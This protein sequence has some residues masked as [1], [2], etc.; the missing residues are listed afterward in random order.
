[1]ADEIEQ[2]KT[3]VKKLKLKQ[4]CELL[5]GH[6]D[7]WTNE[8]PKAN[9]KAVEMH[10]GPLGLRKPKTAQGLADSSSQGLPATC[11][12]APCLTACSWDPSFLEKMGQAVAREALEQ[13]TDIVLAPGVNI[14]RNP[15]CGRNFEYFSEDPLLAGKMG[16]GYIRGVQA[17][18][19]GASLK[20]FA[21]NNQEYRRFIYSAEVDE[22]AL[23]ELYLKPFEIAVKEAKPWTV[24][25][26]YNRINGVYSSEND[27]LL[28]DVLRKEWGY[29]GCVISDWGAVYDPI[30]CHNHGLDLEMPCYENRAKQLKKAVKKGVLKMEAVDA[31][32]ARVATLSFLAA[33]RPETQGA[34]NYGM[35][36]QIALDVAEKSIVL[37]K[38][39]GDILPFKSFDDVCLVGGLAKDFLYQG[40]GSS[41]VT[42]NKVVSLY[43]S[44]N[45]GREIG[46]EIAFEQGYP[47]RPGEDEK[48]LLINAVDLASTHKT[49]LLCLG[50][51]SFYL[52]EGYD[53]SDMRLPEE[54]YR[55]FDALYAVNPNIVVVL[56]LGSPVELLFADRANAIMIAYL[57][58]EA[59]G[60][61]IR[62]LLLGVVNPSG[63]LAETWPLHY[64]DVPSKDYYPGTGTTSLYKESIFVGYRY[65]ST[66][67][68]AV[69]FPFGHGLSYSRF[70]Y[71]D[72][73]LS[74]DQVSKASV[75]K[76]SLKITNK[77][78]I[79]GDEIVQL[80]VSPRNGKTFKAKRELK[81]FSRLSIEAGKSK[82]LVFSLPYSAFQHYDEAEERMDVEGGQYLLEIGASCEDIRLSQFV[83]VLSG[84]HALDKRSLL[85]SYYHLDRAGA[86]RIPDEE[87]E[88]LL[89]HEIPRE[90]DRHRR[91]FNL[92]STLEEVS[93]T[94]IG[95]RLKSV[96][97]KQSFDPKK[98]AKQNELTFQMMLGTPFRMLNVIGIS[99]KKTLALLS[100]TNGRP[101]QGLWR[102]LFGQRK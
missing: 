46:K 23:R 1:M 73:A 52:S 6:G 102:L 80:Y 58:G 44:I 7:W 13:K 83:E 5:Y 43:E 89:G 78:K 37:A 19:V 96:I 24:M 9:L 64:M 41:Q 86:F 97:E 66:A 76:I 63:K 74:K 71:S 33:S 20:H 8:L 84:Y 91:P 101:L 56:L 16:A 67:G 17:L 4:K 92:N 11:F 81:A 3:L 68:K 62:D 54:Q 25:C 49:V 22:R 85:P 34:F 40:N 48:T 26:S 75:L 50:L 29:Q 100:F 27:W 82:T 21:C 12:P 65:F 36:H 31:A 61:A 28:N 90:R 69:C 95:R 53:R 94:F 88:R 99:E 10:D 2:A 77:S 38:N 18:G 51:P 57:T 98:D 47:L 15:L 59:G 14:K 35:G 42:P 60:K 55:L 30:R 93:G 45:E 70:V 32:A 79:D 87:F 39:C 72:L